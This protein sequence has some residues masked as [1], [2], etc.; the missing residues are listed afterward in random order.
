MGFIPAAVVN[1]LA[2]LG[3]NPGDEREKMDIDELIE[4][5]SIADISKKSSVF[6]IKKLEW[7][8]GQYLNE[9]PSD[10]ILEDV[11]PLFIKSGFISGTDLTDKHEYLLN[12]INLLKARCRLIPDFTAR[13]EFFF[14]DPA[15]YE[16][17]GARKYFKNL[18]VSEHLEK[19]ADI[20]DS[21]DVFTEKEVEEATRNLAEKLDISGGKL[22]HPTRLAVTGMTI[23]PGLFELLSVV[24]KERVVSRMRRAVDFIR[25]QQS[26]KIKNG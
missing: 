11:G 15:L 22:I 17:K 21:L 8:N 9:L 4:S 23:G 7:L 18:T 19:L 1:F 24:G 26:D 10:E 16:E 3:W 2:F 5:F 20:F 12:V 13:G 6:D 14:K 25:E